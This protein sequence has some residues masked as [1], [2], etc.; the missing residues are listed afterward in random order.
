MR[1]LIIVFFSIITTAVSAQELNCTVQVLSQQVQGTENRVFQ[2]LETGIFEFMNNTK[3]T[4]DAFTMDER[5]EC[6][7]MINV[8]ERVSNDEFKAT[9]SIQSRRPIYKTS[10]NSVMLNY[11][12]NDFTFRYLEYQPL[13]FSINS[14]NSNLTSVLAYYAYIIIGLDYDSFSLQ[15]GTPYF[16]KAQ[17]IVANAQG[18]GGSEE[19]GWKA[20][21]SIKNRYWYVENMINLTFEPIR[22]AN[23]IIHRKALDKMTENMEDSRKEV[24]DALETL[25]TVHKI[26]PTSYNM[27]VF[28]NA[29]ADEMVN[30]FAKAM[31]SDKQKAVQIL[32]EIDPGNLS[33]YQKILTSN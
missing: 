2:T 17:T 21:L 30:I 4:T 14:F 6:S 18:T 8:T 22:S 25:K 19:L 29:K 23:Y 28:F 33:K 11:S 15:G 26:K 31:P 12:D 13:E 7:I 1:N 24:I 10:Y 5:I 32:S 27:Q 3:W 16:Q 9:I 20:H